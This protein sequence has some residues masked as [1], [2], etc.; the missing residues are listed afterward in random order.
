MKVEGLSG[1]VGGTYRYPG[2]DLS[3]PDL[4]QF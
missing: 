3:G 1:P 2:G 4:M